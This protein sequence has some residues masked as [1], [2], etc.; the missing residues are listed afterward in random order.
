M[1]GI[2]HWEILLGLLCMALF[3]VVAASTAVAALARRTP[4]PSGNLWPCPDCGRLVSRS[5]GTCLNVAGRS[6]SLAPL[7][8]L[9]LLGW[10]RWRRQR[11]PQGVFGRHAVERQAGR[12]CGF[13]RDCIATLRACAG[14]G[15]S[16]VRH[17]SVRRTV[18]LHRLSHRRTFQP[19][20]SRRGAGWSR[21]R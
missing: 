4:N 10:L 11:L 17:K 5:A 1:F 9:E 21:S 12:V 16:I 13:G 19:R 15:P 2:G 20:R 7:R 8:L 6:L 14:N 3:A 18:L